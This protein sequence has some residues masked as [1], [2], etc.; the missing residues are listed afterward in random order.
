MI[1]RIGKRAFLICL[2]SCILIFGYTVSMLM[3]ECDQCYNEVYPLVFTGIGYSI[4]C[5]A[6]WGS[7]PYV[8]E[9]SAMGTAFGMATAI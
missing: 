2:S 5:A 1:D 7:I 3:P 9:P 6:I 8:V 4:Y